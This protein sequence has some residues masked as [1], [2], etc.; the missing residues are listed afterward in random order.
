MAEDKG[1]RPAR[2]GGGKRP[3]KPSRGRWE[4]KGGAPRRDDARPQRDKPKPPPESGPSIPAEVT[5]E[6][7][8][9]YILAELRTL[10]EGKQAGA[11]KHLV[12]VGQLMDEDPALALEHAKA[13]RD[14]APRLAILRETYGVAAYFNGDY[15]TALTELKAARRISGSDEFLPLIADSE[16][17]LGKPERALEVVASAPSRLPTDVGVEL[18]IV[19]AGARRDLGD[20]A[21]AVL[22]LQRPE[23]NQKTDATWLPRLRY[24]YADALA[25]VGRTEE[26]SKWFGLAAEVD[27]D[28]LTDAEERMVELA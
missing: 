23:L 8:E 15:A 7:L 4:A 20:P 22:L 10:P 1:G 18:L 14:M 5:G 24:A 11:A 25:E 13:A 3:D 17:G 26:A 6:E 2:N 12:M 19:A 16:R 27:A 21:A 9:R 28:F